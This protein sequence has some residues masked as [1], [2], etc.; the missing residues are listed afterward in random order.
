MDAQTYCVISQSTSCH[1]PKSS[2]AHGTL[3]GSMTML[4]GGKFEQ[5]F[6]SGALG[7]VVATGSSSMFSGTD[8]LGQAMGT[9]IG[10]SLAGGL[11]ATIA[12]GN[13]WDGVRN[14]AISA[15]LNHGCHLLVNEFDKQ[16]QQTR[17]HFAVIAAYYDEKISALIEQI[18]PYNAEQIN[19]QIKD[20]AIQKLNKFISMTKTGS[21][22][23][24]KNVANGTFS[25][26]S[27]GPKG[28]AFHTE[29]WKAEDF[30]NYNFGVAAKAYGY[31]LTF[32]QFGAGM[33]Q[34]YS[35]TSSF[36]Y[37]STFFDSPRDYKMIQRGYNHFN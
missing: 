12:G 35:G 25:N 16:L 21:Q 15:G 33:Y 11:G 26:T 19:A 24:L 2:F 4:S 10:G 7:S 18:N 3:G 31:S 29:I 20:Y 22:Y 32:S 8:K 17:K 5:G 14:G 1:W 27:I 23:D 13:F 37:I 36:D 30:G 28:V 34:I 9:V 6:L